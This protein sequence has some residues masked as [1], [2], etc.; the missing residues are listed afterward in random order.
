MVYDK[1]EVKGFKTTI[2]PCYVKGP[3]CFVTGS[4]GPIPDDVL[5]HRLAK[6]IPKNKF[7][8]SKQIWGATTGPKRRVM[9]DKPPG[10]SRFTLA[11]GSEYGNFKVGF[12]AEDSSR[13][14]FVC[15]RELES[16]F[17]KHSDTGT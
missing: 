4:T 3:Q 9:F 15:K 8:V 7:F 11:F 6:E 10:F 5:I 14:C 12:W 13:P 2:D 1:G 17:F 16:L